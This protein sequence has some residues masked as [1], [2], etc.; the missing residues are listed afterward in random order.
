MEGTPQ[1]VCRNALELQSAL[2]AAPEARWAFQFCGGF[3][4]YRLNPFESIWCH[5]QIHL[6]CSFAEL[7]S[8]FLVLRRRYGVA[9]HYA[10]WMM[11][12]SAWHNWMFNAKQWQ[13]LE[14]SSSTPCLWM[15]ITLWYWAVSLESQRLLQKWFKLKMLKMMLKEG[16]RSISLTLM[17][18]P[19]SQQLRWSQIHRLSVQVLLQMSSRNKN[20]YNPWLSCDLL[21]L[22][23]MLGLLYGKRCQGASDIWIC[24][25]IVWTTMQSQPFVVLYVS[26]PYIWSVSIFMAIAAK[27]FSDSQIWC[28]EGK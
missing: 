7:C 27:M 23:V 15:S 2:A 26:G 22:P 5:W 4:S 6:A 16:L 17:G 14:A 19:P 25:K 3:K 28:P 24:P 21:G 10:M 18:K 9:S 1:S 20:S 11:W 12:K 8:H 13:K